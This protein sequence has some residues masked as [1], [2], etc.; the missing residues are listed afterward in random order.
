MNF[1]YEQLEAI[2]KEGRNIIVSAG[3]GSGKTAVLT[4]RVITKLKKGVNINELLILTFTNNAA[5]EMKDRIKLKIEEDPSLSEQLDYIDSADIK[6]FDAYVLSLVKRYYYLIGLKKDISIID[7]S[8]LFIKR[9]KILDDIFDELYKEN[10]DVFNNFVTS[11]CIKNDKELKQNIINMYSKIDLLIDKDTYLNKYINNYYNDLNIDY[12]FNEYENL[13]KNYINEIKDLLDDIKFEV[14]D[15]YFNLYYDSLSPLLNSSSYDEV[16]HNTNLNIPNL[17]RGSSDKAKFIKSRIKSVIDTIISYTEK[18]K[19]DYIKEL[20]DTKDIAVILINIIKTLSDKLFEYKLSVN[21]FEYNDISRFA[22]NLLRDNLEVKNN[23]KNKYNEIMVDEYQDTSNIQEIF[24]SLIENNNT[25]V[26]GDIKQ[27]IYRFRNANPD[28]FKQ[29]YDLYKKGSLGYK[30]DLNKNF[31]SRKEVLN[32]INEIFSPIMDYHIG[33]AEYE[34]EHQL[35]FG[36]EKY[37]SEGNNNQNNNIEILN[38]SDKV[39]NKHE[40]EA[41]IIAQDIKNKIDNK[42]PVYKNKKVLPCSYDDF[43]ILI[44]RTTKFDTYKKVFDYYKIPLNIFKDEDIM[45]NDETILIK[46]I[47]TLI[48]KIKNNIYD[49]DFKLSYLSIARSYLFDIH[50]EEIFKIFTNNNFKD[51]DI[52]NMCQNISSDVESTSNKELVEK[53]IFDFD[54]YNK[55]ITA[56]DISSRTIVL[57]NIIDKL[58]DLNKIGFSVFDLEEYFSNL[59]KLEKSITV[60]ATLNDFDAVTLTNIH[61]SKGLEYPICYYPGLSNKFNLRDSY[62]NIIFDENYGLIIPH[63][64]NIVNNTFVFKLYK[65]D[66]IK[67]EISEKLRLFYVSLT[68]CKE[69]MIMITNI[70]EDKLLNNIHVNKVSYSER[71]SYRSFEDIIKSIYYNVDKYIKNIDIPDIDPSYKHKSN[72]TLVDH[73]EGKE[74]IVEEREF[75]YKPIKNK[76]YS[77]N[78]KDFLSEREINN[79]KKGIE[80]HSLFENINLINPDYSLLNDNE[81]EIVKAFLELNELKNI[82]FANVFKEYE[83]IYTGKDSIS[84]GVIDLMLV[85]DDHVDIIDYKLKNT[86]DLA[87]LNQMNGYK[88]FIENKTNKEVNIYLYSIIEKTLIKLN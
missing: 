33:N 21:S 23:L 38:Y 22:I 86:T 40:V 58:N 12:L 66:Y 74:I 68:R 2:N 37:L 32:N 30:I 29:K 1:T 4:E 53:I 45:Q 88:D 24:I 73:M 18:E 20:K 3:A 87:Y 51:T 83:F 65:E 42:Y 6:T 17:P 54:F 62:E 69:K 10:N 50:D 80:L 49:N 46:N 64:K 84:R 55:M 82:K 8:A 76:V 47:I 39:I 28:I 9:N 36:L 56:G 31:R 52:Y 70:D 43:T 44:D 14:E 60:S 63:I 78:D 57:D 61:K 59:I 77:K 41:F 7:D 85:Y 26:V 34:K 15:E 75:I 48:F 16:K 25:Y 13:I 27:S 11:I 72:T 67:E 35:E 5:K 81:K 79:M 71:I 19:K